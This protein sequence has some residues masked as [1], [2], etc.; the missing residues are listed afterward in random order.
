[1]TYF[2]RKGS[3]VAGSEKPNQFSAGDMVAWDLGK[4]ITHIGIVSDHQTAKGV[5]L[6]IHNIG[7]GTQEEDILFQFRIIGHYRFKVRS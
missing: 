2:S 5:P 7:R 6:I 4:G 1:M 3:G